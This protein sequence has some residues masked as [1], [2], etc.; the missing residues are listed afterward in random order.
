MVPLA[1]R[2]T[3]PKPLAE[4]A[5]AF[6][7]KVLEGPQTLVWPLKLQ[8]VEGTAAL[9]RLLYPAEME[10]R[11]K[12]TMT[13]MSMRSVNPK[14]TMPVYCEMLAARLFWAKPTSCPCCEV[15]A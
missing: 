5:T 7:G 4:P 15:A 6:D 10:I 3:S 11:W 8:P 12:G 9:I 2:I 1:T 14:A 13:E